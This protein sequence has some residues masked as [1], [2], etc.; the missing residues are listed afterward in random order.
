MGKSWSTNP[1]LINRKAYEEQRRY[2]RRLVMS[3]AP[4][5]ICGQPIDLD[6]PQWV[7]KD[8]KRVRSPWSLEADH[9][10]PIAA[11]GALTGCQAVQPAHRACNER[12]GAGT[13]ASAARSSCSV[14]GAARGRW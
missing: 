9:I 3:G 7:I 5:A 11:G 2:V 12:K 1:R 4:C 14:S 10:T 13:Q 8:G 6:A